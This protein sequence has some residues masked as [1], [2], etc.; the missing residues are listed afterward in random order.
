MFLNILRN[1]SSFRYMQKF[2]CLCVVI[3]FQPRILAVVKT[4]QRISDYF[5]RFG[6]LAN[7]DYLTGLYRIRRNVHHFTVY[8]D[9]LVPHQLP[10]C[11]A[12]RSNTHTEYH[13]VKTAL[14]QLKQDFTCNT[15]K[16]C[17]FLKQ[18]AELFLQHTISVFS[19]LLLAKL[20]TVFRSLSLS[21]V[22]VLSG[23]V[24]LLRQNFIC[25]KDTFTELTGYS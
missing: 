2:T 13:V 3:P 18:I 5:Q 21:R 20:N 25:S 12:S 1:V 9:V 24:V 8:R 19:F 10:S 16:R 14:Q 6:T 4:S 15:L 7:T 22:T 23:R 11:G 17:G